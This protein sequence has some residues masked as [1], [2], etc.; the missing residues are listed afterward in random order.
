MKT[1]KVN[2]V[3]LTLVLSAVILA[4]GLF[5]TL[6]YRLNESIM[7]E[8]ILLSNFTDMTLFPTKNLAYLP[9]NQAKGADP[10]VLAGS[11]LF[12]L[13]LHT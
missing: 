3:V 9:V 12:S 1:I 8:S 2:R 4:F 11:Q 7:F 13:E 5:S 6:S 10:N